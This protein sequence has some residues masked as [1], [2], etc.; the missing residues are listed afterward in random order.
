MAGGKY[1]FGSGGYAHSAVDA[2]LPVSME[3]R[4]EHRK[5]AVALAIVMDRSGSMGAGVAGGATKMDLADEGAAR[6]IDLL[7]A[8]DAASVLAVDTEPHVIVP[9]TRLGNNRH[10]LTDTVRRISSEGGGIYIFNGLKGGWDEL[11]KS[12]AGQRHLLLF[13]DA[14]D[15]PES[16]GY[17]ALVAEMVKQGVT[18]SVIGMGS[19]TD[20]YAPLLKDIAARGKGQIFFGGDPATLPALFEQETVAMA[21]SAFLDDPVSIKPA[22]GW[23]ELAAKP[24]AWPAAVDGYNLSYLKPDATAAAY[25]VDEYAAPLLAFWQRGLGRT[26]AVSFPLGGDYSARV[27]AWPQYGDFLQTLTRWLMGDELPPG[28]ALRPKVDGTDLQLDLFYDQSWEERLAAN[29]PGIVLADGATGQ[30]RPVVWEHLEPGHFK[31]VT[32]LPPGQWVRGAAQLGKFAVP[33][34]PITAGINPEWTFDHARIT[35][36]QNVARLSGG[37]ERTDLSKVWTAP[38]KAEFRDLRS[39]LLLVFLLTFLTD[40][41]AT[42]LGWQLPR[43]G[44]LTLPPFRRSSAPRPNRPFSAAVILAKSAPPVVTSTASSPPPT[45]ADNQA[46]DARSSRFRK[47]K[48]GRSDGQSP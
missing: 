15:S 37:G 33:F 16:T 5:L 27:R 36:L 23:L 34:G 13:A 32:T 38:R 24:L 20:T 9:L 39:P 8:Q 19:D 42:R 18:V 2:L 1:A 40:T 45:P 4:T 12:T 30:P 3:L 31:A 43:L 35:E 21:R 17:E 29:P 10:E 28:L 48:A 22:A 7:G 26:A 14:S 11:Q 25:S 46:A 41:L 44:R 47:A 6:A